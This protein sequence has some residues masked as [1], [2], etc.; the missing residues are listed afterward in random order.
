MFLAKKKK[1][2]RTDQKA[3]SVPKQ[4]MWN[5]EADESH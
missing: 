2:P 5:Y 1:I 4:E 3:K